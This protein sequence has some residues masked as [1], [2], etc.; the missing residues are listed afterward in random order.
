ME[1]NI[2]ENYTHPSEDSII[3]PDIVLSPPAQFRDDCDTVEGFLSDDLADIVIDELYRAPNMDWDELLESVSLVTADDK[4]VDVNKRSLPVVGKPSIAVMHE[5]E[6]NRPVNRKNLALESCNGQ[7]VRKQRSS[8]VNKKQHNVQLKT[9]F[10]FKLDVFTKYKVKQKKVKPNKTNERRLGSIFP[11]KLDVFTKYKVKQKKVKP[12]PSYKRRLGSI[13]PFKNSLFTLVKPAQCHK[14]VY[15][16]DT[17]NCKNNEIKPN[18]RQRFMDEYLGK[19][20]K[21]MTPRIEGVKVGGGA[22]GEIFPFDDE[23]IEKSKERVELKYVNVKTVGRRFIKKFNSHILDYKI[24]FKKNLPKINNADLVTKALHEMIQFCKTKTGW[25]NG[26]KMNIVVENPLFFNTISTGY[27]STDMVGKLKNKVMQILTSDESVSL[28][29]SLFTIHVVNLPKGAGSRRILNLKKDKHTKRC[30]LQ[31]KNNDNLCAPRAIVTAMT[32]HTDTFLDRVLN[33]NEIS[34]IRKGRDLQTDLAL[35][36]CMRLIDFNIEGFTLEDIRACEEELDVQIKVVCAENFNNII[37]KGL[38]DCPIKLYLYKQG[39]HFDVITHMGAFYGSSYYCQNCDKPYQ[40]KDRAHVCKTVGVNVCTVCMKAEHPSY[41]KDKIFCN[42][43][44]RY[45]FNQDCYDDHSLNV[46]LFQFK[47]RKCNV[48]IR[49]DSFRKHQCGYVTCLNCREVVEKNNHQ[50][51]MLRKTAKGGRCGYCKR[52]DP[53]AVVENNQCRYTEKYIFFDYE[54]RQETGVH[55]PNLIIAHDYEGCKYIFNTNEEFCEWLIDKKHSGYTAI[56]HYAKG[57]DAQFILQY[58]IANTLCPNTL[59]NGTKIMHLYISAIDLSIVDSHNFVATS[60][61][62]FPKT[63]GLTE[64]KKGYFPHYFNTEE[65]KE[66]VG[67]IPEKKYYG[68]DTMKEG[69]RKE[70]IEWHNKKV[71]EGY[72]FDMV[73]EIREYCE[74][75]VD[76]LRRGCIELRKE[77]LKI[78][79]IDPFQYVT[80]AGVCMA[81][82]RSRYLKSNTIAVLDDPYYEKYSK[83]SIS[84]LA[85]FE[86]PNI[87]HALNGGEVKLCGAKVDGYDESTKTVYQ[88]HGCFWH[89][90]PKCYKPY[91]INNVKAETMDNLYQKTTDRTKLLE[92]NGYKVV[93]QWECQWVKTA[94][95]K[96]YSKEVKIIEP[97]NPRDAL[98]GGRTEVFKLKANS[99]Q[100]EELI[101]YIDVC[102]LYPSVMYYDFYPFAH[103]KK[104]INPETYDKNWYGLIKCEIVAPRDL[105]IPVLPVRVL[106][107]KAEKLLFPLCVKCAETKSE[108]CRHSDAERPFMGT[109]TTVEVNRAI[110]MGYRVVQTYEVWDFKKSNKLWKGYITDFM[111]IKLETSPHSYNSNEEYVKDIYEKMGIQLDIRNIENNPGKRAMAKLCLNSLWGKFGQ[112]NNLPVTEFVTNAHRFYEIL[113]DDKLQDINV[114]YVSDEM[115][116]VNYRMRE[117]YALNNFST[118]IFVAIYTTANARLRLYDQL[119]RLDKNVL[120]CDTDSI[121]YKDN[122]KNTVQTGDMLGEWTDELNGDYITKWLATGPKSYHYVT[123]KGKITTKV[124]G[125]TLHHKNAQII[126]GDTLEQMIDAEIASVSVTNNEITRDPTTKQLVNKELTKTLSFEFDKRILQTDYDTRPYGY[127]LRMADFNSLENFLSDIPSYCCIRKCFEI[128]GDAVDGMAC[129]K[130]RSFGHCRCNCMTQREKMNCYESRNPGVSQGPSW[131]DEFSHKLVEY[132]TYKFVRAH[133]GV[134]KN[135]KGLFIRYHSGCDIAVLF[136]TRTYFD[137]YIAGVMYNTLAEFNTNVLAFTFICKDVFELHC[138]C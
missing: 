62:S 43:C 36:L 106:M 60:L 29:D 87:R 3:N 55:R 41:T 26:D 14:P 58:C 108:I 63:F 17:D 32:Y 119:S 116:Q 129:G 71:E 98:Y 66:Y 25:T 40:N 89:G 23:V 4:S 22:I 120:Y 64:L 44:N 18:L 13:F 47:C 83:Q 59:Y 109:W 138:A 90:C 67:P 111:K 105:Y 118:N 131:L 7:Y 49:R 136:V 70:F 20:C 79:N 102:S 1:K 104:I 110:E 57:Y 35:D 76:I 39:N 10:P 75:D 96:K 97:L 46:C 101:R 81:I 137:E 93:E 9:L 31:I 50:C 19:Q 37:Y 34:Y 51:Y 86:D 30:I 125:F 132:T 24:N 53:S 117:T 15:N 68:Y 65:N 38:R 114:F 12:T 85:C 42:N 8:V 88:Y 107:E 69:D 112:R 56:A 128:I 95:Y 100:I 5:L 78:A 134:H 99:D 21:D 45:C 72:I 94:D 16:I 126:N 73:K 6:L 61:R 2:F 48:L 92:E 133:E 84:W 121:V 74:S 124:K 33:Q 11:F 130:C 135:Q 91:F 103:P 122:G 113:L 127:T 54:A 115:V 82:Y 52:C 28:T 80:I 77:F 27:N 123:K